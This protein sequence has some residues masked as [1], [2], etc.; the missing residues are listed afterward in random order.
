MYSG[1]SAQRVD[2]VLLPEGYG[3]GERAKFESACRTF[4]D[5]FFSY[6]PYK[7]NAAR[8]NVRAVWAPSDDSGVTIPGENV[9]RNT[10]CGAS[11]IPSIRNATRW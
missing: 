6:S 5:E 2:I 8:F 9:W 10:A 3:A 11:S 1:N 4:A 7:E